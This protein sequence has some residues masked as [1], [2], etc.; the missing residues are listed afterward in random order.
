M[1]LSQFRRKAFTLIEL[2]VVIAIIA[3]LISLLVPAVQK[4]RE[5]AART[6]SSNNLKQIALGCHTYHDAYKY[7]PLTSA[8]IANAANNQSGSYAY[9]ILPYIEQTSIYNLA[10]GVVGG[11]LAKLNVFM[12]PARGRQG[13]V[14]T[15]TLVGPQ[16]DYAINPWIQQPATGAYATG[17]STI[18]TSLS[19]I[20]DGTSNTVLVGHQSV[21]LSQYDT[22]DGSV[23]DQLRSIFDLAPKATSR[24]TGTFHRD[25]SNGYN[26]VAS[27]DWGGPFAQG[28]LMAMCDGTVRIFPYDMGVPSAT[29]GAYGFGPTA[30]PGN[31]LALFIPIDGVNV[32]L[33]D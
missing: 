2:L 9:Q 32:T 11:P 33:P 12:C 27:G 25:Y 31:L 3:I 30:T 17:A 28:A 10:N 29:A 19:R 26:V 1:F 22:Q 23:A 8:T 13:F 14:T 24:L 6:Q 21:T 4:V 15:N 5:A 20:T 7:L 18:K 16:C